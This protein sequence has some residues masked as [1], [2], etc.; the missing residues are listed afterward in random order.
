MSHE[1]FDIHEHFTVPEGYFD[2]LP[3]R[4][5]ERLPQRGFQPLRLHRSRPLLWRAAAA[6]AVLAVTGAGW[7]GYASRDTAD[8]A[9][10]PAQKV[11][12][13]TVDDVADYAMLD[14][15]DVYELI[16]E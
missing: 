15:Q 10:A 13:Y 11:E 1:S 14:R 2:T 6:V 12:Q 3:E 4:V 16:S 5:M 8:V 9:S 7:Y